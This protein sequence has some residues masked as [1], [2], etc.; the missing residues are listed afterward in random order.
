M[1][2]R[3]LVVGEG[4]SSYDITECRCALG[5]DEVSATFSESGVLFGVSMFA[6]VV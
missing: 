4:G 6:I 3:E 1:L 2:S 5:L